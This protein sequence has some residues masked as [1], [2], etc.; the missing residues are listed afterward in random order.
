M[1][2]KIYVGNLNYATD[3]SAL[4]AA[5]SQFGEVVSATVIMDRATNRSKGFGF[6][7]MADESAA[8]TAISQMNGKEIDGRR[9]RVNMAEEKPRRPRPDFGEDSGF[10]RN[11]GNGG[12]GGFRRES[13][14][15]SYG[16]RSDDD[17]YRY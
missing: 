4:N 10:R 11:R 2:Q 17:S 5:F 8:K 7:E 1:A 9:V 15:G 3:D 16:R 14:S 13:S 12:N 6:V